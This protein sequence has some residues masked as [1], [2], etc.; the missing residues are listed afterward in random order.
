MKGQRNRVPSIRY[1]CPAVDGAPLPGTII[2]GDGPCVRRAYRVLSADR[3]QSGIA[4]LGV[5][6]WRLRVEPMSAA[7]GREEIAAGALW[8]T[9][10]W[11]RRDR[12]PRH[13]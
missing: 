8:W 7:A 5:V 3:T 4:G 2:M 1:R 13:V 10:A 6:T 12:R 11:D 9:I